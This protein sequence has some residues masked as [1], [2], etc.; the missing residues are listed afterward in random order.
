MIDEHFVRLHISHSP[1]TV[2][3]YVNYVNKL[4]SHR[5]MT[6]DLNYGATA[7]LSNNQHFQYRKLRF[8]ELFAISNKNR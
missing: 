3:N 5:H 4:S 2:N 8:M 6:N 1:L 7:T